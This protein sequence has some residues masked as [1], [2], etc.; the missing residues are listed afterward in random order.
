[1]PANAFDS[2]VVPVVRGLFLTAI[3]RGGAV[4]LVRM[5]RTI[6]ASFRPAG[7]GAPDADAPALPRSMPAGASVSA[8]D[9]LAAAGS[10]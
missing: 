4:G 3:S 2:M 9:G 5:A 8:A 6:A 10:S 7:A 1:M